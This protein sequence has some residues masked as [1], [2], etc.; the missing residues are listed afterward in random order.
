VET[1]GDVVAIFHAPEGRRTVARGETPGT[2]GPPIRV[3]EGRRTP[4][5]DR[6]DAA[7]VHPTPL[8]LGGTADHVHLLVTLKQ[9][10]GLAEFIKRLKGNSSTWVHEAP[11]GCGVWWQVGYA[12][13]SVSHSA[14]DRVSAYIENQEERHR[15]HT[16]QDEFRALLAQHGVEYDER[17]VWD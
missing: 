2:L 12:A 11:P 13:S 10:L 3:P 16:F 5:E 7:D 6:P 8:P 15:T 1:P 14:L 4:P 9:H 17:Y